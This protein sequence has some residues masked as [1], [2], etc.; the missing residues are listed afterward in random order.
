MM[1]G[2]ANI[3]SSISVRGRP[4]SSLVPGAT[5]ANQ[6][7]NINSRSSILSLLRIQAAKLNKLF[8][9]TRGKKSTSEA[10]QCNSLG[11]AVVWSGR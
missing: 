7:C 1:H 6:T 2:Q 9:S 4:L 10:S 11:T 8:A 3:E 5:L